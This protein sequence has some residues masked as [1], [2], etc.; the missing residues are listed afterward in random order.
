MG[1]HG[2][3][4]CSCVG[5]SSGNPDPSKYKVEEVVRRPPHLVVKVRY[6]GVSNYEGLKI[7]VYLN[8]SVEDLINTKTLDPHFNNKPSASPV[9]FARFEPTDDG[10]KAA[11][12]LAESLV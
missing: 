5:K 7:L 4:H 8:T 10:W 11:V 12:S 6:E 2:H 3:H 9:P 1:I